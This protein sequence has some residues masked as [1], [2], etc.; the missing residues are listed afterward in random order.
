MTSERSDDP[1]QQLSALIELELQLVAERRFDELL[2]L[3]RRRAELQASLPAIPPA[4]AGPELERCALL[5]KRVEIELLRVREAVL[6]EL[7]GVR[8][9]QRAAEGYAPVRSSGR[10]V[11]AQA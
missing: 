1:Y 11:F 2:A 10:R 3:K 5:H 7:A 9:A 6:E 4:T 8:H